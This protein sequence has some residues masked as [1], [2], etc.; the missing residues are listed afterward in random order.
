MPRSSTRFASRPRAFAR[1][2]ASFKPIR[3]AAASRTP[4]VYS[5]IGPSSNSLGYILY[6]RWGPTPSACHGS[7]T[8]AA[9]IRCV[10]RLGHDSTATF[11]GSLSLGDPAPPGAFARAAGA[12]VYTEHIENHDRHADGNRRVGDVERPEMIQVPVHI[13]EVDHRSGGNPVE[14]VARSAAD[15]EREAD[16]RD[17]LVM[18]E[19]GGIHAHPDQRGRRDHRDHDRLERE[20]GVVEDAERRAEV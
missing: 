3:Y 18:R 17:Q 12:P 7:L 8:L 2:I 4:Y 6:L 13:D 14:Q 9:L 10:F 15:D 5:V 11:S 16:A 1:T 20:L 19:A